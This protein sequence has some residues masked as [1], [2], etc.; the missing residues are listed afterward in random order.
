M[1]ISNCIQGSDE[2]FKIRCGVPSSSNFDK[3]VT[4]KGEP[5]KQA[6]KYGYKLAGE[7]IAGKAEETYKNSAMERGT[8]LEDEARQLYQIVNDVEVE[9]VGF[10]KLEGFGCSP[11]GLVGDKGML[12]IKCP[13]MATHVEY[14]LKGKMPTTYFQQVQGQLL[15]MGREWCDFM[16]YYPGIKPFAIRVERDEKFLALLKLEL[17]LFCL[18]LEETINKIR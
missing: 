11:D 7:A 13:M 9:Q 15:V 8:I 2:W 6:E 3:I 1:E 17:K 14:L 5:S 4:T 10:C 18:N 12:E 16:S